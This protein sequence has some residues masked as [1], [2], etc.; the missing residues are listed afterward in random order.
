MINIII[1]HF[2]STNYA[3]SN[4]IIGTLVGQATFSVVLSMSRDFLFLREKVACPLFLVP[5][6]GDGCMV[7]NREKG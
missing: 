2:I 6:L 5:L 3:N 1:S 4:E 7:K